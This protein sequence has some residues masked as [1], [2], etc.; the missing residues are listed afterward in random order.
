MAARVPPLHVFAQAV[1]N[2]V[3]A[4]GALVFAGWLFD[5]EPLKRVFPGL[6]AMKV[7]TALC[8]V[9]VGLS[10]R[11]LAREPA[12]EGA[13]D[14]SGRP[15]RAAWVGTAV[16]ALVGLLLLHRDRPHRRWQRRLAHA[17]AALAGLVALLAVIGYAYRL[18]S[19]YA[20]PGAT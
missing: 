18:P 14:T 3:I 8:F 17:L 7:N 10:L 5:L 19:L 11:L 16:V 2:A 20:L 4:I 1:A 13:T 15:S 9:L 12:G 6:V